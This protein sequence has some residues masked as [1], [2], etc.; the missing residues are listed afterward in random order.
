MRRTVQIPGMVGQDRVVFDHERL[1]VYQ[2]ALN[3]AE[4]AD[5]F[6]VLFVGR[7]R[8]LG[9]QL[10]RAASGV[11]LHIAEGNGRSTGPDRAHFLLIALGSTLDCA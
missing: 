3:L 5:R 11:P 2:K 9:W 7:R 10:H 8:H 1:T 6:S 4:A